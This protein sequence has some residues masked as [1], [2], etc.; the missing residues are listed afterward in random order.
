MECCHPQEK[1]P[2]RNWRSIAS[3]A[4]SGAMLLLLPKCPMCIAAYLG[5]WTSFGLAGSIAAGLR[6]ALL[7]LFV[8]SSI[9]FVITLTRRKRST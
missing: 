2:S 5:L 1:H 7:I 6:P 3:C 4:G 8:A 9:L